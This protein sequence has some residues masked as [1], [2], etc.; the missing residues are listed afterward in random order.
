MASVLAHI[1]EAFNSGRSLYS[2]HAR[3]EMTA[4]EFGR[5]LDREVEE[6]LNNC[7]ILKEYP[8][9]KPYPSMLILGFT[10]LGRPLHIV[11]AYRIEEG[12]FIL[13]TV[14]EPDPKKWDNYRIRKE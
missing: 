6:A 1:R 14:Y 5:I 3:E 7:E 13:V 2:K 4:E 10:A 9:D 12:I 11:V 8:G